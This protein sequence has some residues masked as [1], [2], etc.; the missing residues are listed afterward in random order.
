MHDPQDI[1]RIAKIIEANLYRLRSMRFA[2]RRDEEPFV[3]LDNVAREIADE[4]LLEQRP[5]TYQPSFVCPQCRA[6]SFHPQDV[7]NGYCGRCHDFTG[8]VLDA[9]NVQA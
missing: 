2:L 9:G 6:R 5:F 1:A 4:L 3:V 7:E 8:R